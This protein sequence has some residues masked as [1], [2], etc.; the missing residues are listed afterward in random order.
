MF[1]NNPA[2]CVITFQGH[3]LFT[4][5]SVQIPQEIPSPRVIRLTLGNLSEFTLSNTMIST[6]PV[7]LAGKY[8]CHRTVSQQL[9]LKLESQGAVWSD[10]TQ[11]LQD[12]TGIAPWFTDR[13]DRYSIIHFKNI[14]VYVSGND[15]SSNIRVPGK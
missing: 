4:H 1:R 12:P 9:F 11:A 8:I 3:L 7:K 2:Y 13:I 10:T 6:L 5:L 14:P 15:R